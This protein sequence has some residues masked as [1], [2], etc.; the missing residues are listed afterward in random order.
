MNLAVRRASLIDDRKEILGL[1]NRNF[2]SGQET[3]FEWRHLNHPA[4][5]AWCWFV[6][7]RD[8][9]TTV[10]TASVFPRQMFVDGKLLL[11][12]QVGG[13]AVEVGY[14]SLGPA[15]LMQRTTFEPVD[16][17]ALALCYDTPPHDRGM[18]TFVR[19]G[20]QPNCEVIRFAL[21]LRSDEYLQ[22]RFGDAA[23]TKALVSTTNLLLRMKPRSRPAATVPGLE[24]DRFAERFDEE[25]DDL[26]RDLST[27]NIVRANRSAKDLNWSYRDNPCS[28]FQVLVARHAGELMGYL[29]SVVY[30]DRVAI[31]DVFSRQL[32]RV[33]R[34]L[35]EALVEISCNQNRILVEGSCSDASELKSIFLE[36]G[37]QARERAA[38]VVAY[39]RPNGHAAKLLAPDMA[40]AFS[41]F[42]LFV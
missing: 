36:S 30:G 21:P 33:G 13:F 15:V 42:D 39:E 14:R 6:Y 34:A 37:F 19:L 9:K 8:S 40:W 12:G 7:D 10:A 29:I 2:V 11:C 3:R 38:R 26:D 27:A 16:S 20:M 25:F 41:G 31:L 17:G 5:P 28:Q 24:I 4:G 35:V 32:A 22:K 18:S 23:W 1:L